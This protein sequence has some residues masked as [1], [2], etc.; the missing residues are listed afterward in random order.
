MGRPKLKYH[1]SMGAR[2]EQ[3]KGCC[4]GWKCPTPCPALDPDWYLGP[5]DQRLTKS[6]VRGYWESPSEERDPCGNACGKILMLPIALPFFMCG[7]CI[8]GVQTCMT[9]IWIA[10]LWMTLIATPVLVTY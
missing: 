6:M 3:P 10:T 1:S 4:A 2:F 5:E 9:H 7:A 8:E